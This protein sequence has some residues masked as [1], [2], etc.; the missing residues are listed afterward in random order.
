MSSLIITRVLRSAMARFTRGEYQR[1]VRRELHARD[2]FPED[3]SIV[4]F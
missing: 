3:G 1:F 2:V 4:L